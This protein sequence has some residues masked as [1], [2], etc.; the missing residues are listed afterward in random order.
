MCNTTGLCPLVNSE[1]QILRRQKFQFKKQSKRSRK[2]FGAEDVSITEFYR[3][4]TSA[5][6]KYV[7]TIRHNKKISWLDIVKRSSEANPWGEAYKIQTEKSK[8]MYLWYH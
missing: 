4:F 5:R 6:T 2:R 3:T 7:N 1:L 8:S